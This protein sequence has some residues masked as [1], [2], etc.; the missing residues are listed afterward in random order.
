MVKLTGK[1]HRAGGMLCSV[2]GFAIL[3]ENGLLHPEI[4][5]GLQWAV[6][7]PFCMWGSIV[8]DLDH[9][10]DSCPSKDYPS[11][12][13]NKVL[14]L[15]APLEK[16]TERFG[17]KNIFYRFFRFLNAHH[18]SWQTH[19]DLT[20]LSMIFLIYCVVSQRFFS[21]SGFDGAI[22]S[23]IL[24]G[25]SLGIIAHFILDMLTPEGVWNSVVVILNRVFLKGKIPKRFEK[26]HF[27]PRW[28]CFA[29]GSKWEC[30]VQ[31][32]LKIATVIAIIWFLLTLFIP[33]WMSYLK[34]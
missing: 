23:L 19:S 26:W 32:V 14:H 15:T 4:H 16:V 20:L 6:M 11:Y 13:L 5:E 18:R 7:Y 30:F 3:R 34:V 1:T 17:K 29:T 10:W 21:L 31:K 9:H 27:V 24:T 8:S 25:L 12:I 33:N 22:L 2:V 28:K